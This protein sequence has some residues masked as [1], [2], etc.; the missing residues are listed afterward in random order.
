MNVQKDAHEE[1]LSGWPVNISRERN[2][3]VS[4]PFCVS[5]WGVWHRAPGVRIRAELAQLRRQLLSAWCILCVPLEC[6]S[7]NALNLRA[8]VSVDVHYSTRLFLCTY[9][10]LIAIMSW[11]YVYCSVVGKIQHKDVLTGVR[12]NDSDDDTNFRKLAKFRHDSSGLRD[13]SSTKIRQ[14]ICALH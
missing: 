8:L 10:L 5:T 12:H 4:N 2:V 3:I 9:Q 7:G 6:C 13:S 11:L 1:I 14:K